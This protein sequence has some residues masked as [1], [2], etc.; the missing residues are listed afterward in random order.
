[1]DVGRYFKSITNIC[2]YFGSVA[3]VCRYFGSMAD[4]G[5]YSVLVEFGGNFRLVNPSGFLR[6]LFGVGTVGYKT[7]LLAMGGGK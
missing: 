1:M 7:F 6:F 4:V 5:G 2:G 3:D